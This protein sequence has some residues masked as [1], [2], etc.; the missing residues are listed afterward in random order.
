[1]F[2]E[3]YEEG[4]FFGKCAELCGPSHSLMD[5]K[6]VV[7]SKDDYKQWVDDM[8]AVAPNDEPQDAIAQEGKDLFEA[9]NCMSCHAIGSE[10]Y[11]ANQVPIGPD[12]TSFGDRS[13]FAG[14]LLPT[15][16]NLVDWIMDPESIKPGNKMTGMY[17][18]LSEEE[19]DKIAEYLLQLKPSSVSVDTVGNQ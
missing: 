12:L 6:I 18:D 2:I 10:D 19:A 11:V 4:V 17:P 14:I 3:A 8:K 9:N 16:E 7:V 1:M 13:R 5:F 15:K